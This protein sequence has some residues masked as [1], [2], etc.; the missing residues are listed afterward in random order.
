M[1]L[2]IRLSVIRHRQFVLEVEISIL[3]WRRRCSTSCDQDTP[4]NE[5]APPHFNR[6]ASRMKKVKVFWHRVTDPKE[7]N[8]WMGDTFVVTPSTPINEPNEYIPFDRYPT[9]NLH[10]EVFEATIEIPDDAKI[11]DLTA[12]DYLLPNMEWK[13]ILPKRRTP[14]LTSRLSGALASATAKPS[15]IRLEPHRERARPR[16]RRRLGPSF[17]AHLLDTDRPAGGGTETRPRT[18]GPWRFPASD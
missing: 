10:S 16:R 8:K 1:L 12:K 18:P 14:R 15:S 7:N 3:R 4:Y 11:D 2:G 9:H 5:D 17:E 6:G 13:K